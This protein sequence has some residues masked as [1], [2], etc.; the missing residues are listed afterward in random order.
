[1]EK[2][3][4]KR[5]SLLYPREDTE[6]KDLNDTVLHDLGIDALC[7][8]LSDKETEQKMILRTL[9]KM[10]ADPYVTQY[11]CGVFEDILRN[12]DMRKELMDILDHIYFLRNYSGMCKTFKDDSNIWDLLHCLDEISDY[13]KSVEGLYAVLEGKELHSDGM[14]GL[15]SFIQSVYEDS[16]FAAMKKDIADLKAD[17]ASLRSITL[18]VNLNERFE[19][20]S[21]GLVSVNSKSFT[22]SNAFT[23]FTNHI[24]TKNG[25]RDSAEWDGDMKFT[26][27]PHRS[28]G[29]FGPLLG[30]VT[31]AM[32]TQM[33]IAE[34]D[35]G[36][37]IARTFDQVVS[38]TVSGMVKKLRAVL[39]KY[40]TVSIINMVELMPELVYYIRWAEYIE[41]EVA[42]GI[43]FSKAEVLD[44]KDDA[45]G[46]Y[47]KEI[48]NIKLIASDNTTMSEIVTNDIDFDTAHRVYILTG[49]NRG[50]KTTITQAVGQLF[51][52]AQG[53]I[54]IPGK[55]LRFAPVD[56]IFTHFPADEDKTFDLGRLG[57]ECKR[58]KEIFAGSTDKSL[59]LLNETFSTTSF[60]EGY[61]IAKDSIRAILAKGVR[62]VYNTHMHK[63]AFD[64]DE[65]NEENHAAKAYSLVVQNDGE[66][67]SYKVEIAPP[68]GKSFAEHI[69]KKY[70]VTYDM[71]M[72]E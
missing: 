52:L 58:F 24:A 2:A 48:Y 11:R 4:T 47:A 23:N 62:T 39:I 38:Q 7:Q 60:E 22:K 34:G 9:S 64:L 61:F 1:M 33:G 63:L 42:R 13:I 16:G 26:P 59:I 10:T 53:G 41:T 54:Y 35:H 37:N 15:K 66:N 71:L 31:K 65:I 56:S 40:V 72:S 46:M 8:K 50:G 18:G 45:W 44:E 14:L 25:L 67:R 43:T 12:V 29:E 51:V 5:F 30:G 28:T 27:A 19:A 70:G 57:E 3:P 6:Y 17:T 68:S 36:R 69:A 49:A 21:V 32:A 20:V 55:A